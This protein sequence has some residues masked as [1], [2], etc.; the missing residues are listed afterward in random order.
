MNVSSVGSAYTSYQTQA[1]SRKPESAEVT[2][3]GG[4]NDGDADDKRA[5]VAPTVTLSGQKI[6]SIIN[7]SA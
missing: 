2:S 5:N 7:I 1:V 4:D 6:G 3:A